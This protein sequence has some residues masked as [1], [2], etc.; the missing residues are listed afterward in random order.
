MTKPKPAH[1]PRFRA[2]RPT[3][4]E[5]RYCEEIVEFMGRGF[6]KTAFAGSIGVSHDTVVE[7]AK[8]HPEFS[9]AV[10]RG[11]AMRTKALEEKLLNA[12]SGAKVAACI[13]SLKNAAPHEWRD[14]HEIEHKPVLSLEA[15]VN[16][17]MALHKAKLKVT[18]GQI[19]EG[20]KVE[21]PMLEHKPENA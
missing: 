8:Q 9:V 18:S 19:I 7:W 14:K 10:K 11:M 12:E 16:E 15:I 3:K 20:E 17:S 2:G 5:A 6:R 21:L 13:F 4:Y 1:E